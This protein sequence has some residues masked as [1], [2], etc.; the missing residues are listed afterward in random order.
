MIK[1]LDLDISSQV[2]PEPLMLRI[3]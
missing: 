1:Q 3:S 2:F